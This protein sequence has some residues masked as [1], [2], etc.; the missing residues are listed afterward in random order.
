MAAEGVHHQTGVEGE[1][2]AE[3]EA[4]AVQRFLG[5]WEAEGEPQLGDLEAVVAEVV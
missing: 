3:A 4:A 5:G 2:E 1:E